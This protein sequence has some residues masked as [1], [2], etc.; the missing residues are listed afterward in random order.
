MREHIRSHPR[1]RGKGARWAVGAALTTLVAGSLWGAGAIFA[2]P[3]SVTQG[4]GSAHAPSV[5][6]NTIRDEGKWFQLS[7]FDNKTPAANARMKALAAAKKLPVSPIG[8][9]YHTASGVQNT[10]TSG[11][12]PGVWQSLGPQPIDT[13]T[14]P[15]GFGLVSGRVTAEAV[16][17]SDSNDI[18]A[19]TAD[20]GVWNSTDGGHHWQAMTDT[21][22]TLSTGAIAIDPNNGNTIYVG[23]GEGNFN[24]DAYWGA[25][26]L[27]STDHGATWS[28]L[29]FSYFGGMGFTKIAIDPSNSNDILGAVTY[30]GGTA[31][32]GGSSNVNTQEGIW[33]ST[34]GGST[35]TNVLGAG[36]DF[37][38]GTD[39][40]FD[41]ANP[42]IVF[43]GVGDIWGEYGPRTANGGVYKSTNHGATWTQIT[44]NAL[45]TGTNVERTSLGISQ[46]GTHLYAAFT[47]GG[48]TPCSP[49]PCDSFGNLL[50][51][52]IYVSTDNGVT[53]AAKSVSAYSGFATDN[54]EQQWWYDSYAAVDP[55]NS[56]TAYIGGVDI[57]KTTDGGTTWTN[58]T[59]SYN[60]GKTHPDQHALAFFSSTSSSFYLGNDGGVWSSTNGL[61]T[62]NNLNSGGLNT[63]QFYGG[64]IG[65]VGTGAQIYGG[66][67][68]NGENQFPAG[69]SYHTPQ[70]WNEVFGGDGFY[71]AV[72]YTNNQTV[73]EEYYD[74]NIN[75]S[76]N[77]GV[78]WA[79]ATSGIS[80]TDPVNFSA[81]F[82]E[83]PN[84]HNTLIAG[85]D[86]VYIST[87]GAASWTATNSGVALDPGIAISALAFAPSDGLDQTMFA[88]DNNGLVFRTTNGG[89]NWTAISPVNRPANTM[90]TGI[91][92]DPTNAQTIYV[93]YNSFTGGGRH[94]F[95]STDGGSHWADI[96]FVLPDTPFESV[97]VS[98]S[99]PNLVIA[100]SDVGIFDSPDGGTT[101][102]QLG[103]QL[104]NVAV[105]QIFMNHSGTKLFVATHGRGMWE[106]PMLSNTWYFAE[107][108]TGGTFTEYLTL[109]N[110]NSSATSVMV[111]YLVQGSSAV[112]KSYTVNANARK[113]INI[114]TEI[115]T[116]KS[117]SMV[118][119]GSQPIVAERPMYFTYSSSVLTGAVPGGS[120]VLGAT[121]LGTKFDFGYID[122]N[123]NHDTYFSIL[124]PNGS[125]M[126]ATITYFPEAGGSPIITNHSIPAN[127]RGTVRVTQSEGLAPGSYSASVVL[128]AAGLVERPMYLIDSRTNFTGSADVIGVQQPLTKWSFAEGYTGN[129]NNTF[130]ERYILSNPGTVTANATVTFYETTGAVKTQNVSLA[131]GTQYVVPADTLLGSGVSNSAT[132]TSNQPI[133]AE[134]FQSFDYNS[135]PGATDVLGTDSP[136][137]QFY[138]A[139]GFTG[140]SG[141][142]FSEY[143]TVENPNATAATITVTFLPANGSAPTVQTYS[144]K[145]NSRFTL[146]TGTVMPSQSFSMVVS[147]TL[148]VVAERP[149]YF[150]Y[151]NSGQTG[152]SDVI[153]YQP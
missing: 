33:Q 107:G 145:A 9:S 25:G 40:A 118:V 94:I 44:A 115:G 3:T 18:W 103:T 97:L 22:V 81:P 90:V 82:V 150:N 112:A 88:G 105:D 129:A 49:T 153:G 68:D 43:A 64:S 125:T 140:N 131:A 151:N 17:P 37:E 110:P 56:S 60:T 28:Q 67:Q 106:L 76:T 149:M 124:N 20:G 135:I 141:S 5:N 119:T 80:T 83:S 128:S 54:S 139:E 102:Y 99:N 126:T 146:N 39:L 48:L 138:F 21:Q 127:S 69:A 123:A 70:T 121:S 71:T 95:K 41:P 111:N 77:G 78:T 24:G 4:H 87:N 46:D 53:W 10:A 122:T 79:P 15:N 7:H 148:P 74:L 19:G 136:G 57:W 130:D 116:G 11:T 36:V 89:A 23:T 144:I 65:E 108:Y 114:N 98:P 31:P 13:G 55:N 14:P 134:R 117:V 75:K 27:K 30:D 35:W 42:A 72:D 147:S 132:V 142:T 133:L 152:G 101:W 6:K 73:Y 109:E 100:G 86:H 8:G 38:G 50:N 29:G 16:N 113:T 85:T 61:S 93:S 92:V 66:A 58:A 12:T 51:A 84:N 63:I 26:V 104:P 2:A 96:S 52:A 1:L 59:D 91:A 62:T 34:D 45:P 143:L 47:D 120:D 137:D 32:T